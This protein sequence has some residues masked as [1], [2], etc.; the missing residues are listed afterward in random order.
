MASKLRSLVQ[1]LSNKAVND[2]K[3]P[4]E[5]SATAF[6][7]PDA[8]GILGPDEIFVAFSSEQP[9]DPVTQRVSYIACPS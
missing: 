9:H 8:E 3:V 6:I 4:V 5:Q 7:V 2:F 1:A